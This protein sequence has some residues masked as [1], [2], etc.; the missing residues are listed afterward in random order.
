M[1]KKKAEEAAL[2]GSNRKK[3]KTMETEEQRKAAE[4]IKQKVYWEKLTGI[5]DP[6]KH[7]VWRALEKAL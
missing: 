4:K 3:G 1:R 6:L 2:G 5:L 7:S